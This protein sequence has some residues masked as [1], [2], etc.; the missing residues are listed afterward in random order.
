[1]GS[2]GSAG[3]PPGAFGAELRALM[4]LAVPLGLAQ[5]GQ[6]L[7]GL[8]DTAVVGRLSPAA[9]GGVGLGNGIFF[10]LSTVGAGVMLAFDPLLA[11]ALGARE[12]GRPSRLLRQ[13]V[14]AA[15]LATLVLAPLVIAVVLALEPV[16]V[17]PLVAQ[18]ARTFVYWRLAQLPAHLLFILCRSWLQAHGNAAPLFVVM[19]GTNLLN[20]GLDV[21]LVFGAGPVPAMGAAG[22]GLASSLCGWLQLA[23][24]GYF[25][26]RSGERAAPE[27]RSWG[28]DRQALSKAFALGLPI[29]LQMLAEF[30]VFTVVGVLAGRLGEAESAAHQV[31]ITVS[32]FSFSFAVGIGGAVATRVGWAV[33]AGDRGGARRAGWAGFLAGAVWMACSSALFL[34]APEALTR[35]MTDRP[36][37]IPVAV[38]LFGV[39]AVFQ[40]SDG[41]QAVGSGAL[42]GAGDARLPFLANLFGHW[43]VGFPIALWLGNVK[44]MG[45]VGYWWGLSV[46]LTTVALSLVARFALLTRREI[47]KL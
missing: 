46:G 28:A 19:V 43:A 25:V 22:A 6:A 1:M 2:A 23:A 37:V 4:R 34:L 11:Q 26:W 36:S 41:L 10:T 12:A 38:A 3:V 5:A 14:W 42:R 35:T 30:S 40:L 13:G 7:L 47:A 20:W 45:V 27:H 15:G 39:A 16:G 33:G 21:L 29:G 31:A 18:A 17:K 32:S 9:M 8:V 44:G 24:L